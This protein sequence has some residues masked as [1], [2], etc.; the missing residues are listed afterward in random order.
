[1]PGVER[2][3]LAVAHRCS[4]SLGDGVAVRRGAYM[5]WVSACVINARD[6][7][8]LSAQREEWLEVGVDQVPPDS[9]LPVTEVSS[10]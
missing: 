6:K 10:K 9:F 3:C 2:V 8:S 1:M 5:A 7:C 4:P